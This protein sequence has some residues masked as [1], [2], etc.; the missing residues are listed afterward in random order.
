LVDAGAQY[1][2]YIT[3]ISRTWPNNGVFSPA[4]RDLY[5]A[6]LSAQRHAVSLCRENAEATLDKIHST[7]ERML[8]DSLKDLGFDMSGNVSSF[9]YASIAGEFPS[10]NLIMTVQ[11]ALVNLFP[12]HIGHYIG[13]DV[14][15][16]PGYLRSERLEA[17][18]CI[19]IEPY[20]PLLLETHHY[21]KP[22]IDITN[23]GIY[24]PSHDPSG[25]WPKHFRGM[26]IR[27]EDSVCVD[28]EAPFV[29][30]T[31][32]VKE[33]SLALLLVYVCE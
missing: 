22:A 19:T 25:R 30:S 4:Q 20:V 2:G 3:D 12:H 17:G 13:L 14:H 31:E 9:T 32:A 29:L 24:V 16:S 8:K 11:K 10:V 33:V 27:I 21:T 5:L 23:S 15:D 1:G 26:G 6:V 7:A 28:K 18:M